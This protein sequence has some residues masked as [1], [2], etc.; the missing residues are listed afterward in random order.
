MPMT[1]KDCGSSKSYIKK[2]IRITQNHLWI[3]PCRA[4]M[5]IVKLSL[6]KSL[7]DFFA[8]PNYKNPM[9]SKCLDT[10]HYEVPTIVIWFRKH[11]YKYQGTPTG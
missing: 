5:I 7:K 8:T 1:R 3:V 6:L 11:E 4:L 2:L 10:T 9:T